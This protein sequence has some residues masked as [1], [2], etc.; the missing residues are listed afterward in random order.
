MN[1]FMIAGR[2]SFKTCSTDSYNLEIY[3]DN[4]RLRIDVNRDAF[5]QLN[6]GDYIGINGKIKQGKGDSTYHL[7]ANHIAYIGKGT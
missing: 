5:E 7:V 3:A 4:E 1:T 2:V 6:I